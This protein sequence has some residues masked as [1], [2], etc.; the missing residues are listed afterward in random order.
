V[1]CALRSGPISLPLELTK[2]SNQKRERSDKMWAGVKEGE[3]GSSLVVRAG[4]SS[5]S[6]WEVFCFR[7]MLH[8]ALLIR[9]YFG[10]FDFMRKLFLSMKVKSLEFT[11]FNSG[12]LSEFRSEKL[13][14]FRNWSGAWCIN[15]YSRTQLHLPLV[16]QKDYSDMFRPYMW[17]IFR[18]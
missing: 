3:N 1:G 2:S 12:H 7:R 5:N 14:W 18:L 9:F 6:R 4:E 17:S 15:T 11:D 8:P 10:N 13:P 16:L